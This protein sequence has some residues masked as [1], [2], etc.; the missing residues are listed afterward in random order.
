MLLQNELIS[1]MAT[2][3]CPVCNTGSDGHYYVEFAAKGAIRYFYTSPVRA[4]LIRT[5][6]DVLSFK[7]HFEAVPEQFVLCIDCKG[8]EPKHYPPL[9]VSKKIVDY[10]SHQLPNLQEFWII[11]PNALVFTVLKIIMPFMSPQLRRKMRVFKK[12]EGDFT[13]ELLQLE[14]LRRPWLN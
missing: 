9:N 8:M 10:I 3:K 1:R 13:H 12:I 6:D 11:N 14:R 4:M 5:L 2:D 7:P